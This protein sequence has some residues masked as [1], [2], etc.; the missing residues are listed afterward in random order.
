MPMLL[1]L[2]PS[3]AS[4]EPGAWRGAELPAP[5]E[6]PSFTLLDTH[7][8][9]F[10]FA[11]ETRDRLALLF[12]GY[13]SCPDVCPV[14]MANLAAVLERQPFDVRSRV[15]VIFVSTDP[16]RDSPARIR[17]WLDGFDT[18]FIGLSGDL[19]EVNRIQAALGLPPADLGEPRGDGEYDV[20]HA[21]SVLAFPPDGP[22]R[23]AYPFGTRQADWE[24]DLPRLLRGDARQ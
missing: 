15:V 16:V 10:D 24:H 18:S 5:V 14:H 7:G 20:G 8:Q 6:R 1:S 4:P 9:P 21:A 23:R 3:C 11:T 2:L 22:A 17:T 19:A 13:A 12:F